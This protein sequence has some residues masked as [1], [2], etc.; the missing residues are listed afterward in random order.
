MPRGWWADTA[1]ILATAVDGSSKILLVRDPIEDLYTVLAQ[2]RHGEWVL[3]GAGS[4]AAAISS[5]YSLADPLGAVGMTGSATS[6]HVTLVYENDRIAVPVFGGYF[7][8]I[9]CD[10]PI[11]AVRP[12]RG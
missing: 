4:G 3:F 12:H 2:Y 6:N 7:A 10:V 5:R 8:W 9:R 11:P 1:E